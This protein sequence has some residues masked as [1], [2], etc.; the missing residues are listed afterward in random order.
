M[1]DTWLTVPEAMKEFKIK[2]TTLWRL[3]KKGQVIARRY[4]GVK[5]N[6][7]LTHANLMYWPDFDM[8]KNRK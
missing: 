6:R 8:D 7:E 4:C 2:R 5:I 1:T 3:I